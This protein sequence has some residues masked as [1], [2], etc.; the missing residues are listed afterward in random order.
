[1]KVDPNTPAD[2]FYNEG[3][4]KIDKHDY[5]GAAKQFAALQKQYPFGEWAR[6]ALVMEVYAQY[7]SGSYV[8]AS[9]AADRF[10]TLYPN[11]PDAPYVNYLAAQ[12]LYG[13]MPDVQ[14]DQDRV[15]KAMK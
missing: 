1:M 10:N 11:A 14:R 4:I 2:R 12:A 13:E 7:L 8:D 15:A 9:S 5:E 3:L 6:K